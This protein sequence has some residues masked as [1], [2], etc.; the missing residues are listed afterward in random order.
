MAS[1][2]PRIITKSTFLSLIPSDD[3]LHVVFTREK[4]PDLTHIL[5]CGESIR[6]T[7]RTQLNRQNRRLEKISGL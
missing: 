6:Q 2:N 1:T 7:R 3:K 5:F 4:T